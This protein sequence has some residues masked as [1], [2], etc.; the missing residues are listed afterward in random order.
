MVDGS[1]C[2]C[3]VAENRGLGVASEGLVQHRPKHWDY[4]II[5][6]HYTYLVVYIP[7]GFVDCWNTPAQRV[8][9]ASRKGRD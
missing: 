8:I 1:R 4:L 5:S 3:R 6:D 7:E 2:Q 9:C